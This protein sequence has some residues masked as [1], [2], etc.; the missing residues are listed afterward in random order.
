[1]GC[2]IE[3]HSITCYRGTP[4]SKAKIV[5]KDKQGNEWFSDEPENKFRVF[6]DN[7]PVDVYDKTGTKKRF[8]KGFLTFVKAFGE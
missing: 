8:M 2:V 3:G 1:M 7:R 4:M 5:V 6:P